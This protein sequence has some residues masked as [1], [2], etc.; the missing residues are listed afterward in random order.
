MP[1]GFT[2]MRCEEFTVL[3]GPCRLSA[4]SFRPGA[5]CV[6]CVGCVRAWARGGGGGQGRPKMH[7]GTKLGDH[8]ELFA[9]AD[10]MIISSGAGLSDA[11]SGH[12]LQQQVERAVALSSNAQTDTSTSGKHGAL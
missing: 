9:E 3:R 6:Q 1:H 2:A 4:F 5:N 7:S 8:H 11:L 10:A 12:M